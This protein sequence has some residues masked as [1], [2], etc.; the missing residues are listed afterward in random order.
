MFSSG[1]GTGLKE[2]EKFMG[3]CGQ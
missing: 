1:E 3:H 2:G